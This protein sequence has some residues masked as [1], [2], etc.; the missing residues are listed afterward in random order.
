[1]KDWL[2]RTLPERDF[3]RL[4]ILGQAARDLRASWQ[5]DAQPL[6]PLGIAE[7]RAILESCGIVRGDMVHV[8]S[9]ISHLMKASAV[10]PAAPVPGMRTYAKQII[11]LLHELVGP[12]GTVMMGT[13]FARPEGWL[14]RLLTNSETDEDVFDPST[15]PS[16]R[17]L[18]SEF[19]RKMPGAV[20]SV[21]PYYNV[22]ARGSRSAEL[23]ADHHRSTPYAQDVHSPWYKLTM[24]GGK[25]LLLGRTF[26]VNSLVHLV[27]YLHPDEYPRPLFMTRPVPM[28]YVQDGQ[29]R[30]LDVLLHISGA[31]GSALFTPDAL[32][33]FGAYINERYNV[34]RVHPLHGGAGIVCYTA[35]AQYDAF[36]A[37]ARRNVTWYDPQFFF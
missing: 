11:D 32:H 24:G 18:L 28:S 10:P 3:A 19:F 23:M 20:R 25:V 4:Q 36:L 33:K 27:E 1:M 34:Y 35:K 9:S 17:G 26:E 15:T 6:Y 13:D 37:E 21:H 16:N 30:R 7:L 12:E 29:R 31:S 22:T 5:P 14:K 2:R 8:H